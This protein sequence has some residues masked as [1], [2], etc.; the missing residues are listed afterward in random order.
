MNPNVTNPVNGIIENMHDNLVNNQQ[1]N[2]GV[3]PNSSTALKQLNPNQHTSSPT[4]TLAFTPTSVLRKMTA[5]KD[6]ENS[7]NAA[8]SVNVNNKDINKVS[9]LVQCNLHIM[10]NFMFKWI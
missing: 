3:S 7:S 2:R 9:V 8:N 6:V 10:Y 5:E 4:P 1:I